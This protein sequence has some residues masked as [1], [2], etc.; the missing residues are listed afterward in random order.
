MLGAI[1]SL[2]VV[3]LLVV[4][5]VLLISV[6]AMV[7]LLAMA[8]SM[9]H[10]SRSWSRTWSRAWRRLLRRNPRLELK[11]SGRTVPERLR[12]E[13][14]GSVPR[15][16]RRFLLG[17]APSGAPRRV[18]GALRGYRLHRPVERRTKV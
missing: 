13:L 12:A 3:L 16:R 7:T 9:T 15:V 4:L 10:W 14:S 11:L 2:A 18:S 5:A 17:G 8:A 1:G 6:V